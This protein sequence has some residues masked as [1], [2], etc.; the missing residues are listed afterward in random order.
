V[1]GAA[2]HESYAVIMRCAG[3]PAPLNDA[4]RCALGTAL[5]EVSSV[6]VVIGRIRVGILANSHGKRRGDPDGSHQKGTGEVGFLQVNCGL[7]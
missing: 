4:S 2:F 6:K 7:R 3:R 1:V 5:H